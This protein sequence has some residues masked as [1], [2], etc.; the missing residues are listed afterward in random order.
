MKNRLLLRN[1]LL[2]EDDTFYISDDWLGPISNKPIHTHDFYEFFIVTE[3]QI[4]QIINNEVVLMSE[5]ELQILTPND[6][7]SLGATSNKSQIRNIAID[8]DYFEQRFSKISHEREIFSKRF[9]LETHTYKE[10]IEKT[11]LAKKHIND[12]QTYNFIMKNALDTVLVHAC[13]SFNNEKILPLWLKQL[14]EE[15]KHPDNYIAGLPRMLELSYKTQGHL[16]RSIKKHLGVTVTEYIN[17]LRLEH[18]AKL[19]QTTDKKIVD[20]ALESG[21]ESVSYFNKI[22]KQKFLVTPHTYRNKC[23]F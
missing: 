4:T 9:L 5:K 1:Y 22:F 13:F 20:I 18:A 8:A 3:G 15:M 16:N 10:L 23:I 11:N 17:S 21:F 7:H 14:C 2:R 12:P 6:G 19:L